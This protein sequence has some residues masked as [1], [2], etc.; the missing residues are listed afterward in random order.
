MDFGI[1]G[2]KVLITG[3]SKGIGAAIAKAFAAEGTKVTIVARSED[4]LKNIVEDIGGAKEG[5]AFVSAN[6]LEA[7]EPTRVVN[8][9]LAQHKSY[10][11]V[12]HN[13]GGALG[14]KNPLS[15][16]DEW[17]TVWRFNVGIA[18]EMNTYLVPQMQKKRWGRLVHIS[19]VSAESG[20]LPSHNYGGAIPYAAAKS[21]LNAYVKGMGRELARDNIVV[22]ALMPGAVISKGKYWDNLSKTN[23]EM[24]NN[25]LQERHAIGRFGTAQEIAPFAI[26]MA[27]E[28]ASFACGSIVSID[29]GR[30]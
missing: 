19:S 12:V 26:F 24:V 20:E 7:G 21:Y 22:T 29:G 30:I 18:I 14:I 11:I 3:G 23:P 27:S 8:E 9:L 13:V 17:N 6:L 1:A 15:P 4:N 25:Y 10:D 16:V 5:H 2:K 28:Q